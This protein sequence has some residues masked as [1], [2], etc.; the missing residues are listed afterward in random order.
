MTVSE[1][2]TPSLALNVRST[3]PMESSSMALTERVC[4]EILASTRAPLDIPS[5]SRVR[6]ETGTR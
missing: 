3:T 1:N 2:L 6:P 5:N 4:P